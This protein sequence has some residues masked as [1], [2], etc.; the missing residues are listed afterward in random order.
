MQ[1]R[2][3]PH[4]I[5]RSSKIVANS[6]TGLPGGR[7]TGGKE[8]KASWWDKTPAQHTKDYIASFLP[9]GPDRQIDAKILMNHIGMNLITWV[10]VVS[11]SSCH[12]ALA[13]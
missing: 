12:L 2:P 4:Q 8:P 5:G 11:N 7:N 1:T 3:D 6:A 13:K 10:P 9:P